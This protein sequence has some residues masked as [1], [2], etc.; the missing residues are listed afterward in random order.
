MLSLSRLDSLCIVPSLETS[1]VLLHPR[2]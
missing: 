2:A 1:R